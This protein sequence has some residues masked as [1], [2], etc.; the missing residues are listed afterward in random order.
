M[1]SCGRMRRTGMVELM[2]LM[3]ASPTKHA[4]FLDRRSIGRLGV[5]RK[6]NIGLAV[7][8]GEKNMYTATSALPPPTGQLTHVPFPSIG[9][10]IPNRR[11]RIV[12]IK[13]L[14]PTSVISANIQINVHIAHR[15]HGERCSKSLVCTADAEEQPVTE[16]A[17]ERSLEAKC[18]IRSRRG[19]NS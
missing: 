3:G 18:C 16:D 14:G 13:R 6:K 2:A 4:F 9:V 12:R 19:G 5:Q 8:G 17:V 11:H 7:Q 10:W 15:V 1:A